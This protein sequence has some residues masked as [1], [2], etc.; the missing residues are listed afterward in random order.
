M[1][2]IDLRT[3]QTISGRSTAS[4]GRRGVIRSA[5]HEKYQRMRAS[6]AADWVA[7]DAGRGRVASSEGD[8]RLA[9]EARRT[10]GHAAYRMMKERPCPAAWP[11]DWQE[12]PDRY[13]VVLIG[14]TVAPAADVQGHEPNGEHRG[15]PVLIPAASMD[16]ETGMRSTADHQDQPT[17]MRVG[18]LAG[19]AMI[20]ASIFLLLVSIGLGLAG[21]FLGSAVFALTNYAAY[22]HEESGW[23]FGPAFASRAFVG[24][25]CLAIVAVVAATIK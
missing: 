6:W 25:L 1:A 4:G 16:M 11:D 2:T 22:K 19:F 13:R 21:M 3:E 9:A 20:F 12:L 10:V 8:R 5:Q 24:S 14:P 7:M 17:I 23:I 18:G 15:K